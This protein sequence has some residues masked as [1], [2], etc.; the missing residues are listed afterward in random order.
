[1]GDQGLR[2][3]SEGLLPPREEVRV[4]RK[5]YCADDVGKGLGGTGDVDGTEAGVKRL[6][7]HP[8]NL[9]RTLQ[10]VDS[11]GGR[12]DTVRAQIDQS[13]EEPEVLSPDTS[14]AMLASAQGANVAGTHLNKRT[15]LDAGEV[16]NEL[17]LG[18]DKR[19]PARNDARPDQSS[20]KIR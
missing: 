7:R 17:R 10:G 2:V 15:V 20:N 8:A 5:L 1:V 14:T 18:W 16:R 6:S 4:W 3:E 11:G 19:A 12:L 13:V 9:D